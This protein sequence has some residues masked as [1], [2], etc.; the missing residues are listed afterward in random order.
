MVVISR[1]IWGIL[2]RF[3]GL[4]SIEFI[5]WKGLFVKIIKGRDAFAQKAR[6]ERVLY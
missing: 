4:F 3:R 6:S 2:K 5:W 1:N